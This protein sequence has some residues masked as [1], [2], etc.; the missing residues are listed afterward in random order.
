MAETVGLALAVPGL[1]DICLKSGSLLVQRY[2]NHANA[3]REV[4][5]TVLQLQSIWLG[6]R[7]KLE[8]LGSQWNELPPELQAHE[9]SVLVVL[10]SKL[11]DAGAS[12]DR[13][14]GLPEEQADHQRVMKKTGD[15]R[16]LKYALWGKRS[17]QE[18]IEN[19]ERW[20]DRFHR[21][22][23]MITMIK[24]K[25]AR[26][27]IPST[28]TA[29][30]TVTAQN[31]CNFVDPAE[32]IT[33]QDEPISFSDAVLCVRNP[34]GERV[35]VDRAPRSMSKE[36]V[37]SLAEK[38]SGMDPSKTNL[39]PCQ[40]VVEIAGTNTTDSSFQ[41]VFSI[42][43]HASEIR[44]LR[45][46]LLSNDNNTTSSSLS[47]RVRLAKALANSI[48]FL[49]Q[50]RFVHKNIRPETVVVCR[51]DELDA[52]ASSAHAL[53]TPF[54][55]GFEALRDE[56]GTTSLKGDDRRERN[57]YRH[58]LR[59]GMQAQ[60]KYNVRYDVYSLGVCLL[61]LGL[62][63]A[64]FVRYG[65]E[66]AASVRADLAA[67]K[68]ALKKQLVD[69]ARRELPG[70][71]GAIYADVVVACLTCLDSGSE[72]FGDVPE[73]GGGGDRDGVIVGVR[74]IERILERM[75]QIVV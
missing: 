45:S 30:T 74:Y 38:F 28:P 34:P 36:V 2:K 42:P 48:I 62:W 71:M 61:E 26:Y 12:L 64:S 54:L 6:I 67:A 51:T 65:D 68:W 3:E 5:E 8:H 41:F 19:L 17:L 73:D 39:L 72:T 14:I 18:A 32:I 63:T 57:I 75:E 1:V 52:A 70:R 7:H 21:S 69:M 47:E 9:N 59:Q 15:V 44:T 23:S 16:K 20:E 50:A 49:H 43:K 58:P 66:N 53:G 31:F 24:T 25:S 33:I 40:G 37:Q 22:L 46:V 4:A 27:A 60:D 56:D 35:L 11:C 29:K 13:L 10:H 55:T